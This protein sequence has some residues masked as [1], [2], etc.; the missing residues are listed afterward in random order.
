MVP[1]AEWSASFLADTN[2]MLSSTNEDGEET[3][4]S[5]HM[6]VTC[7][8]TITSSAPPLCASE[9]RQHFVLRDVFDVGATGQ[10]WMAR[11]CQKDCS[12]GQK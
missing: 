6:C 7:R 5:T 2:P 12:G 3:R 9:C 1:S 4:G 11:A 10:P 8:P